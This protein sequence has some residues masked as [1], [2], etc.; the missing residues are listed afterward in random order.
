MADYAAI[1]P[2]N[3]RSVRLNGHVAGSVFGDGV[4]LVT[5]LTETFVG[6]NEG[7]VTLQ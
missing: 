4:R 1:R 7:E 2:L 6:L 3:F 5:N